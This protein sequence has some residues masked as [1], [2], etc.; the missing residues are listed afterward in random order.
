MMISSRSDQTARRLKTMN[1]SVLAVLVAATAL[2]SGY[3][4]H[5][6]LDD[7]QARETNQ[8]ANPA[9]TTKGNPM[10]ESAAGRYAPVNGLSSGRPTAQ[11]A[12]LPG[13]THYNILSSP[14]LAT[15]V[16]AFLDAPLPK[17]S[18]P[19]EKEGGRTSE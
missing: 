17:P 12:I 6:T 10:T 18:E 9:C 8:G 13:C 14:A 11:L 7:P 15:V 16:P 19:N 1:K 5:G 2:A 4:S 3:A